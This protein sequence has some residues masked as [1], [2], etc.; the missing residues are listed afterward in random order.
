MLPP[1]RALA[2]AV[3]VS[4]PTVTA[5]LDELRGE[6]LLVS[7]QGSGTRVASL[8][9]APPGPTLVERALGDAPI[10]LAAPVPPVLPPNLDLAVSAADVAALDPAHG[11]DPVGRWSLRSAIAGRWSELGVDVAPERVLVT[12]GAH[13]GLAVAIGALLEAGDRVLVEHYTFGGILDLLDDRHAAPLPLAMDDVGVDPADLDR[14]LRRGD[15]RVVIL[16]PTVHSP[17]GR[18]STSER[19]RQLAEV[20]DEHAAIVI[21][22]DSLADL[23]HVDRPDSLAAHCRRAEVVT[24]TSFSKSVWGG[25]RVGFLC[26][27]E[28]LFPTLARQRARRDL[29]T[30]PIAQLVVE[31]LLPDVDGV[32]ADRRRSLAERSSAAARALADALPDWEV[33]AP[34]GAAM[35]W[36]RLPIDDAAIFADW[37][38]RHGVGTLPGSAVRVGR[39]ADPHL[40]VATDLE[41]GIMGP[42]IDRLADGWRAW[43]GA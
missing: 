22:D 28:A 17:T 6:G 30:S 18:T 5:A 29:G 27:S 39:G 43:R 11:Y 31:R 1:E 3:S 9:P 40:R 36:C 21:T 25:F 32:L 38:R 26:A 37:A 12:N 16:Q 4:R 14:R 13:H 15:A 42:G 24:I 33:A 8:A 23:H 7:R 35:V 20:L 19:V 41:W 10:N 34:T 2:T